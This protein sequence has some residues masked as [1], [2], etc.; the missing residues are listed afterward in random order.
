MSGRKQH[1]IPQSLLRGFGEP[2][3][4]KTYVVAYT[5]DRGV[6]QTPTDGVAAERNFY[7]ELGVEGGPETLDDKITTYEQKIPASLAQLRLVTTHAEPTLAAELVTH[8]CVR[9]DHFRKV[10]STGGAGL[11]SGLTDLMSDEG[12]SRRFLGVDNEQ[13]S[14]VI[15]AEFT[16]KIA[17]LG[18]LLT[19]AGITKAQFEALAFNELKANFSLLHAETVGM[20]GALVDSIAGQMPD[21]TAGAQKKALAENLSPSLRVDMLSQYRWRT[22]EPPTGVVLPDCVAIGVDA[23]A[24]ILPLMLADLDAVEVIYMPL[25]TNRLL[26][27]SKVESAQVL[28]QINELLARCSWDFFVGGAPQPS[29]QYVR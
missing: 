8:L 6:F 17:E 24:E 16:K 26:I 27:G 19:A 25:A 22:V 1:F 10:V 15:A 29:S 12:N 28:D 3:G 11:L 13:P 7:A 21:L 20:L 4:K 23:K 18:P 9:N 5:F 14:G 2:R